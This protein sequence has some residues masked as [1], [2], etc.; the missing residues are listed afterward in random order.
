MKQNPR[1]IATLAPI[2]II[3]L[4]IGIALH[5]GE[6][7]T[8]LLELAGITE[9]SFGE[10]LGPYGI[11]VL[12]SFAFLV[13][14]YFV[15]G[16][17]IWIASKNLWD[18]GGYHLEFTPASCIWWYAIPFANLFKP[19]QAM[20]EIW[21]NSVGSPDT[22]S[23]ETP[24]LLKIW[25]GTWLVAAITENISARL[26]GSTALIFGC[27]AALISIVCIICAMQ[28]VRGVTEA[29]KRGIGGVAEIFA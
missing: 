26:S 10:D 3:M 25:W 15:F 11:A 7:V 4:W 22:Y 16:R 21:N 20:R 5:G 6:I 14:T 12:S 18:H 17:W 9:P 8:A 28:I 27:V 24:T 19:F 13:L 29:Q 1:G 2:V 23:T